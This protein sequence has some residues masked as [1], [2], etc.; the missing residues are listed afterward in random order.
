MDKIIDDNLNHSWNWEITS[1]QPW[2]KLGI[3]SLISYRGLIMRFVRRDLLASY[4]QT[5]IGPVWLFLQPLLTTVVYMFIFGT[6]AKISTDKTP[7]ILFYLSGII[8]WNFFFDSLSGTMYTFITNA[9]IFSKVYFPRLVLPISNVI[10]Q[11]FRLGVQLILFFIIFLYYHIVQHRFTIS[12]LLLLLPL[13]F[14]LIACF[15]LGMGLM[16]CV[17]TAKYRDV[18]TFLQYALRLMMFA[19]PVV[20]PSS[21]VP[22]KYRFIFWLNPLTAIIETF[23]SIFFSAEVSIQYGYLI[24]SA[25]I[26]MLMLALGLLLFKK[27]E[28]SVMDI[29]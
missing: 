21:I 5:I 16:I 11:A 4:Q 15:A 17:F 27:R 1:R 10:T 19:T 12:P 26:I 6:F 2:F 3:R 22:L 7:K 28:I 29:I 13:L 18:D 23:R 9:N 20:F 25:A 8:L 14:V 24:A